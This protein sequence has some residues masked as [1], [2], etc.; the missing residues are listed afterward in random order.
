MAEDQERGYELD[1]TEQ[2]RQS[3]MLSSIS[4]MSDGPEGRRPRHQREG[5]DGGM[6]SAAS[7]ISERPGDVRQG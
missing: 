7:P 2:Q 5:L 1:A 4:S 6:V 3:R